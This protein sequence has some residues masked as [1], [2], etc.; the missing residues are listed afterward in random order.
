MKRRLQLQHDLETIL[1][2]RFVYFQ[3]PSS[4]KLSYPCIV[5]SLD[6]I[7][8]KK[9]NNRLYLSKKCY[10]VTV[11]DEDP[12][13]DIPEKILE[14]PMCSF[15]RSYPADNLNHWVFILFY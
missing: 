12:D 4:V 11:I 7:D 5:Y 15:D 3:P 14:M 1:G 10:R 6:D 13:S 9:A 8:V 2:S